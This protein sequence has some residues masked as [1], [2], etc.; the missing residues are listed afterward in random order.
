MFGEITIDWTIKLSLILSLITLGI[1][2]WIYNKNRKTTLVSQKIQFLSTL[3]QYHSEMRAWADDVIDTISALGFMCDLNPELDKDFFKKRHQLRQDLSSLM[4]RGKLFLP[5]EDKDKFGSEKELAFR[6]FRQ[7]SL[8]II[9][10]AF[11]YAGKLNYESQ[12]PNLELREDIMNCKR[13]FV[14]EITIEL[15]PEKYV[16]QATQ[17]LKDIIENK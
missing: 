2:L 17:E 15:D 3:R 1:N 6:G 12:K 13:E 8:D 11:T 16:S 4:D 9:F 14:S 7:K 10:N 5:N